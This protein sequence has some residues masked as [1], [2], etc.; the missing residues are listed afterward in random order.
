VDDTLKSE[1][2]SAIMFKEYLAFM[3]TC[4]LNDNGDFEDIDGF[5]RAFLSKESCIVRITKEDKA[6]L[7]DVKPAVADL[8]NAG[9]GV[10]RLV[11]RTGAGLKVRPHDALACLF[12]LSRQ[13]ASLIPVL[14]TKSS[15]PD[16]AS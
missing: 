9:D 2:S 15:V 5:I 14:K 7:V 13:D 4:P 3:K 8:A 12:N 16:A 11:L 1:N 6:T 10:V